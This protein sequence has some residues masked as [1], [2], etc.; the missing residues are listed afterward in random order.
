SSQFTFAQNA[1]T[2]TNQQIFQVKGVVVEV[3]PEEKSV[4]IKHEE[5]PGY[6]AAMT[7]YFDVKDTN[8]LAGVE[9]GHPVAFRMIV[10]ENY[11]WIDQ[12][13]ITG[14]KQNDLPTTG[15]FRLTRDVEPLEV[16]DR[17]P[18]YHF[19]NQLGQAFSTA[20]FTGK[21]WAINFPVN[22]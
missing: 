11:G 19:T 4:K 7:M 18:E 8:E 20:Q 5:I 10:T 13:R 21:V 2:E 15:A 3:T 14:P 1:S 6:M 9:A 17:I 16:G 22:C 12:I